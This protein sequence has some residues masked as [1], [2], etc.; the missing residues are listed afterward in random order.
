MVWLAQGWEGPH[1][2]AA[3]F[4]GKS[5]KTSQGNWLEEFA[6]NHSW[7]GTCFSPESRCRGLLD[8]AD[9]TAMFIRLVLTNVPA[10]H[11]NA[12][13][14]PQICSRWCAVVSDPYLANY[15]NF[16]F[17][18]LACQLLN[19]FLKGKRCPDLSGKK[20]FLESRGSEC[21]I[22]SCCS[23]AVAGVNSNGFVLWADSVLRQR[24]MYL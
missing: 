6:G 2:P 24:C 13:A 7:P 17:Q 9:I 16:A 14:R 20:R 1:S 23:P 5:Q 21:W 15:F 18:R 8:P 12:Q 11:S 22:S 4:L 19:V 3:L 10:A